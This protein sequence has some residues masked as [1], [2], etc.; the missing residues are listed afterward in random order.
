MEELQGSVNS[1]SF[2]S[3]KKLFDYLKQFSDDLLS[4]TQALHSKLMNL[5][6]EVIDTDVTLKSALSSFYILADTQFIENV[7]RI[8]MSQTVTNLLM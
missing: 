5:D 2:A 4:K 7:R 1:W 3:D 6:F 8:Y